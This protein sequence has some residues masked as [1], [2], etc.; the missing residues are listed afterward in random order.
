MTDSTAKA[1]EAHFSAVLLPHRSLGRKGFITLMSVISGVSFLTGIAFYLKGA[2]PV[3]GFF[4]LDVLLVYGA[5]KLNYRAA[6]LYETVELTDEQLTV[7][8][9]HP[10]GR[11]ESWSFN[12]YWVRLELEEIDNAANRLSLRSHGRE[13]RIGTFLSDDEKRGF[14]HALGAALYDVRG[15]RI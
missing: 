3:F 9:I 6:R 7:T 15:S 12:P 11:A 4:G 13:L 8:R 5:F 1:P 14:A 2:W 10:S